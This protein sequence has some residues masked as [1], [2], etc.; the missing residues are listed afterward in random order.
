MHQKQKEKRSKMTHLNK[1]V[2]Y[3]KE[4]I[5]GLRPFQEQYLQIICKF[6]AR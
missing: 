1:R 5:L 3:T 6:S 2:K 4:K